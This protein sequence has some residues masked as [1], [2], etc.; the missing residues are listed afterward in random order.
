M[1]KAYIAEYTQLARDNQGRLLTIPQEPPIVEQVVDYGAGE[2]K[3]AA[4]NAETKI[5]RVHV[6]SIASILVGANPTA[7]T[8]KQRFFA[9]QTEYKSVTP[10]DKISVITNT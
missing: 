1:T 8:S 3:S 6:D 4:F 9:G 10:G 7:T 5:I 2:A